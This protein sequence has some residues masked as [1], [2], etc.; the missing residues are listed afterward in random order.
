MGKRTKSVKIHK[1]KRI[2]RKRHQKGGFWN[3]LKEMVGLSDS[4]ETQIQQQPQSTVTSG[5][6]GSSGILGSVTN[7]FGNI[8]QQGENLLGNAESFIGEKSSQISNSVS[9]GITDLREKGANLIAPTSAPTPVEQVPA[10]TIPETEVSSNVN[11]P[12]PAGGSK[13]KKN[14]SM[15]GG[16][17]SSEAAPVSGLKVAKPTYWMSG[18]KRRTSSLKK[19]KR[20]RSKSCK[21]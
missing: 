17:I 21:K 11:N 20:S 18:G 5:S 1:G 13:R 14:K 16:D 9:E 19:N 15:K 4:D 7:F 6:N 10:E 2:S 12:N 8:T 3:K